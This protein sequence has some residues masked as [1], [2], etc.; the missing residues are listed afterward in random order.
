MM[1]EALRRADR[2]V[3]RVREYLARH[4]D[5][6]IDQPL[7][8]GGLQ[9]IETQLEAR[10]AALPETERRRARIAV[11][12]VLADLEAAIAALA[13]QRDDI[14]RNFVRLSSH[15]TAAVAYHKR[16]VVASPS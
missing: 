9:T 2:A 7:S 1:A 8:P 16:R 11:A 14:S 3:G 5:M 6:E 4:L 10:L 12:P 13:E 15:R